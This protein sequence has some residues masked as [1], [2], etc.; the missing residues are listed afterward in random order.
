[1]RLATSPG[2][3]CY[4]FLSIRYERDRRCS[5]A[6]SG[7]AHQGVNIIKRKARQRNHRQPRSC[8]SG[9]ALTDV[10]ATKVQTPQKRGTID[11]LC[12]RVVYLVGVKLAIID[13][14]YVPD[15]VR[16]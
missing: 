16:L 8:G 12:W 10:N 9:E 4:I 5:I 15:S 1:M 7:T 11:E 14:Q 6:R 3:I 2:L 13:F